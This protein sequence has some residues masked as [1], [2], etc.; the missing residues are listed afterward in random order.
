MPKERLLG[1]SKRSIL[2]RFF[3]NFTLR[4]SSVLQGNYFIPVEPLPGTY[5]KSFDFDF[6]Y[7]V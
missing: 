1:K 4:E 2:F 3:I 6:N 5:I 7:S